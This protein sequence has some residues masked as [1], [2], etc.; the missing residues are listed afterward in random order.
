M[1]E[2]PCAKSRKSTEQPTATENSMHGRTHSTLLLSSSLFC[3]ASQ[4]GW[5]RQKRRGMGGRVGRRKKG[6]KNTFIIVVSFSI[7]DLLHLQFCHANAYRCRSVAS[8]IYSHFVVHSQLLMPPLAGCTAFDLN[9]YTYGK[10]D[11]YFLVLST[12]D[13]GKKTNSQAAKVY[14]V[15]ALI[16]PT[17]TRSRHTIIHNENEKSKQTLPPPE[18]NAGAM[19]S[20][21]RRYW[22]EVEVAVESIHNNIWSISC[23]A[24][25]AGSV[26][27][28][29]RPCSPTS[30][31]KLLNLL[32]KYS[33]VSGKWPMMAKIIAIAT[34]TAVIMMI[35][36]C[37]ECIYQINHVDTSN[38]IDDDEFSLQKRTSK[39]RL[40]SRLHAV[41]VPCNFDWLNLQWVAPRTTDFC[42]AICIS[43]N[44]I[45]SEQRW[46]CCMVSPVRQSKLH[47]IEMFVA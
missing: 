9:I 40:V 45:Q 46:W 43:A 18:E 22:I 2:Q 19:V 13:D 25:L 16:V 24:C 14:G 32:W 12:F 29:W 35:P 28:S 6:E 21:G 36:V 33:N 23:I 4:S 10:C 34:A 30:I 31:R 39:N 1:G 8:L 20:G 7:W 47:H 38:V 17:R 42:F 44:R 5:V 37:C 41:D 3:R 27:S 15:V 26:L 11:F